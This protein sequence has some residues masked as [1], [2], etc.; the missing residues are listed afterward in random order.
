M[1]KNYKRQFVEWWDIICIIIFKN[2]CPSPTFTRTKRG[3]ANIMHTI[4]VRTII[5]RKKVEKKTKIINGWHVI[6]TT[7]KKAT[8]NSTFSYIRGRCHDNIFRN[9]HDHQMN[10]IERKMF[11]TFVPV[12]Y[13]ESWWQKQWHVDSIFNILKSRLIII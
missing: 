3:G 11:L 1:F 9:I 5:W 7:E 6:K 2:I 10:V 8:T 13:V 4:H 12:T